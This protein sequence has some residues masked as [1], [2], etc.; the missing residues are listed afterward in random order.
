[1]VSLAVSERD[2]ELADRRCMVRGCCAPPFFL[3]KGEVSMPETL[4][5]WK[6]LSGKGVEWWEPLSDDHTHL[7]IKEKDGGVH[8]VKQNGR[9]I[10]SWEKKR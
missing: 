2:A 10:V 9:D 1:M 7:R 5:L 3:H 6:E 4:R 8:I